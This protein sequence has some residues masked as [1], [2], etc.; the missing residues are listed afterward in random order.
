MDVSNLSFSYLTK[1][2]HFA[3]PP[4]FKRGG[5][6]W[7]GVVKCF[8]VE[9]TFRFCFS[10]LLCLAGVTAAEK[11]LKQLAELLDRPPATVSG[12]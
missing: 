11:K 12:F 5:A 2:C 1:L 6:K 4:L 8:K 9:N 10:I 3:P 7:Q